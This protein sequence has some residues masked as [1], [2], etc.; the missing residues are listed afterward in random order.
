MAAEDCPLS[1]DRRVLRARQ[2]Y[3]E[4]GVFDKAYRLVDKH[5]EKA[6]AIADDI[7]PDE[8]RRLMYYLVD[9]VLDRTGQV[10]P[11]IEITDL[12]YEEILPI[13]A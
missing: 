5:Q 9:T 1:P 12:T 8:L 2:L 4:G 10:T 11:T 7:N 6:E 13:I 3:F